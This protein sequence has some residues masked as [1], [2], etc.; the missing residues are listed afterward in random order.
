MVRRRRLVPVRR[1]HLKFVGIERKTQRR[2]NKAVEKFFIF[3]TFFHG[4]QPQLWRGAQLFAQRIREPPL[5][6]RRALPER[7]RRGRRR[8]SVPT[9]VPKPHEPQQLGPDT[10][11]PSGAPAPALC[12][13]GHRRSRRSL[14]E[15]WATAAAC[16]IGYLCLLRTGEILTLKVQHMVHYEESGKSVLCLPDSKGAKK[17]VSEFCVGPRPGRKTT[18]ADHDGGRLC[19]RAHVGLSCT[20]SSRVGGGGG[21]P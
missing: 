19:L 9:D 1:A 15:D 14:Y 17:D 18:P 5:A 12:S 13:A 2:Y 3:C 21:H 11:G 6:G 7:G 8:S 20:W 10:H 4:S 16:Y